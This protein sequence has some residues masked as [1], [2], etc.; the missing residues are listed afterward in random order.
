MAKKTYIGVNGVS[1]QVKNIYIGVNNIARKVKK[2]YIG[3]ANIARQ[4][5]GGGELSYYG[6]AT[7]LSD[8]VFSLSGANNNNYA[9]FYQGSNISN[10]LNNYINL[11]NTSLTQSLVET[12][13][14]YNYS[15]IYGTGVSFNNYAMIGGGYNSQIG[16]QAYV[17]AINNNGTYSTVGLRQARQDLT[18]SSNNNYSIFAGGRFTDGSPLNNVD[19]YNSSLV[20]STPT[21]L[22]TSRYGAVSA[23]LNQNVIILGGYSIG[24]G[25]GISTECY[26]SSL[27][28]SII[29]SVVTTTTNFSGSSNNNNYMLFGGGKISATN[30]T[31]NRVYSIDVNLTVNYASNLSQS[32]D[33]LASTNINNFILFGGGTVYNTVDAYDDSLTRT[34]YT[35]SQSRYSLAA[36][37]I[38]NFGLFAGGRNQTTA[39][40]I[41]DVFTVSE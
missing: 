31:T 18:G 15:A 20:R 26:N 34:T 30:S 35:L 14:Y 38:G 19:A 39:F 40:N 32:R 4:F 7:A 23:S 28:K 24:W 29:T 16:A 10:S 1:R 2:A 37:T 5:F 41:V 3:I 13:S 25:Y 17:L 11:Y 8:A 36:A 6:T 21:A 22:S 33:S 9:C 12:P 27:T